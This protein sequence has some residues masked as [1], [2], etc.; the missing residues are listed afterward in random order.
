MALTAQ[1]TTSRTRYTR[2]AMLLHWAIAALILFNLV[3]GFFMEGFAQPLRGTIISMHISSGITVLLLTL[4]RV[5]WRLTHTPPP[6]PADMRGWERNLASIGHFLLYAGMV[7]MP[8]TGW[9][10]VSSNPPAGSPG[11]IAA[12]EAR[13]AAQAAASPPGTPQTPPRPRGPT[14]F[15]W[16]VPLPMISTLQQIGATPGG[17]APQK[18]VHDDFGEL[19]EI[20]AFVMLFLLLLHV[21]GALKHQF[22]DGHDE[23]GRMG[24]GR[25]RPTARAR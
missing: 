13:A 16:A 7:A 4:V 2:V 3:L 8:L 9:A 15:W 12:A 21:A 5:A 20:G 1:H 24:I 10:L 19:H 17:V 25:R 11:A 18:V 14:M 23:L 6:H 22:L